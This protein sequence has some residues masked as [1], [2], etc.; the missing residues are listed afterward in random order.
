MVDIIDDTIQNIIINLNNVEYNLSSEQI[1]WITKFISVSPKSLECILMDIQIIIKDKKIDLHDIPMII[2][3]ITDISHTD[4]VKNKMSTP[5][6]IISFIK[7][8]IIILIDLKYVDLSSIEKTLILSIID[9][10]INLL[11]TNL[12]TNSYGCFNIFKCI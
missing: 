3:L 2:K 9:V 7:Y 11:D 10:S 5:K 12:K 4:A 6:N 1:K 8:I